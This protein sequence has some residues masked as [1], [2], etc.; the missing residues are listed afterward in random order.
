MSDK[1]LVRK[2]IISEKQEIVERKDLTWD[3][4][5]LTY[6]NEPLFYEEYPPISSQILLDVVVEEDYL[7]KEKYVQAS[8]KALEAGGGEIDSRSIDSQNKHE[9]IVD[10]KPNFFGIGL[11]INALMRKRQWGI[12][13]KNLLKAFIHRKSQPK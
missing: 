3:G 4:K 11:N 2:R 5:L 8:G 7:P 10:L 13:I 6:G 1:R 9:D 12:K